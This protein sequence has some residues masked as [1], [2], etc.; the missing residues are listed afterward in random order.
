[1]IQRNTRAS[2]LPEIETV[3]KKLGG[4]NYSTEAGKARPISVLFIG[5]RP[6]CTV[7]GVTTYQHGERLNGTMRIEQQQRLFA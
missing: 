3:R 1:M 4:E 7:Y 6:L 5:L 2:E